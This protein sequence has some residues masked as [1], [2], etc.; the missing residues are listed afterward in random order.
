[1]FRGTQVPSRQSA[2]FRL[3]GSHPLWPA[4]PG[5]SASERFVTPRRSG[6]RPDGSYNPDQ[7]RAAGLEHGPVW[8]PP[9]SLAAT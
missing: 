5:R 8:A 1:M 9:R 4:V 6:S 3:R 2:R 7:H